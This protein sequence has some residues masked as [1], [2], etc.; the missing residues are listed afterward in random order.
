MDAIASGEIK[1]AYIPDSP[2]EEDDGDDPFDTSAVADVVKKIEEEEKRKKRQVDLGL[3][4]NVLSGKPTA[5]SGTSNQRQGNKPALDTS[6][7]KRARPRPTNLLDFDDNPEAQ[8][9]LSPSSETTPKP[10]ASQEPESLFDALLASSPPPPETEEVIPLV[11]APLIPSGNEDKKP[12]KSQSS[13]NLDELL[14]EFDVIKEVPK[15]PELP[16]EVILNPVDDFEDE[17]AA[18]AVESLHK[19][20]PKSASPTPDR[21]SPPRPAPP[22]GAQT[23]VTPLVEDNEPDPF[24]TTFVEKLPIGKGEL[25]LVEKEFLGDRPENKV[26]EDD[27][28]FDPRAGEEPLAQPSNL[29]VQRDLLGGSATDLSSITAADPL[30]PESSGLIE[31]EIHDPFDTSVAEQLLPG[32]AELKLLE[33]ELLKTAGPPRP[34]PPQP[35]AAIA[36]V[37]AATLAAADDDDFDFDPR[38]DEK[39]GSSPANKPPPHRPPPPKAPHPL[40]LPAEAITQEELCKTLTPVGIKFG[41]NSIDRTEAEIDDPF[42]TS[43]VSDV[44][45]PKKAE[46]RLLE[47]ELVSSFSPVLP[48]SVGVNEKSINSS[49]VTSKVNVL[50]ADD[51]DFNPRAGTDQVVPDVPVASLVE[52]VVEPI[53]DSTFDIPTHDKLLT[54]VAATKAPSEEFEDPFDT[55]SFV[56]Q[57]ILPGKAELKF[58]EKELLETVE[59][60]KPPSLPEVPLPPPKPVVPPPPKTP[61]PHLFDDLEPATVA[62]VP[63][64]PLTPSHLDQGLNFDDPFDTSIASAIVPGKTELKILEKELVSDPLHDPGF[65]PRDAAFP[66]VSVSS[67]PLIPVSVSQQPAAASAAVQQ[68]EIDPFDTT[69]AENVVPGKA[70]LKILEAELL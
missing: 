20:G 18:L 66:V 23:P 7:T 16:L 28:D 46:L 49:V 9:A 56:S 50:D 27:F 33:Q 40:D 51:D 61:E 47:S 26:D 10:S 21:P 24:D 70:E 45:A 19:D 55:S 38:K 48:P 69:A 4:V 30:A 8:L 34:L 39:V 54:P 64:R 68:E 29:V 57:T 25:K 58:L 65:N 32:K 41:E 5:S 67:Q 59:D 14:S 42:D 43:N 36:S 62:D 12:E 6:R 35:P 13:L 22:A 11:K 2:T 37:I 53:F 31:T 3:A 60:V 1:L 63:L 44:I 52:T 15:V 17:F